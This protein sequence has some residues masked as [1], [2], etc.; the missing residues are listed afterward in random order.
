MSELKLTPAEERI[1][2]YL[3]EQIKTDT[4]LAAVYNPEKIRQCFTY[5][6]DQ[7]RKVM[8]HRYRRL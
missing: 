5:I 4:A 6:T 8:L 3:E 7:A 1:K 2:A